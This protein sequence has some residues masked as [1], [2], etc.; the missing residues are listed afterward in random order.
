MKRFAVVL[1]M[2]LV[3]LQPLAAA[4]ACQQHHA[5][6]ASHHCTSPAD[7]HGMAGDSHHDH[8]MA[9]ECQAS[10]A[11]APTVPAVTSGTTPVTTVA[12]RVEAPSLA[13]PDVRGSL[14]AV[15]AFHPPK[16]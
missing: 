9:D 15:L 13:G 5:A 10:Q 12:E 2:S 16:P 8:S 14:L 3:Q 1:A 4:A 11:C 6:A 7:Q